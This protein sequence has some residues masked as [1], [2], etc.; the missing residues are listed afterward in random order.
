M[1]A[2][3]WLASLLVC[4]AVAGCASG[5]F[6]NLAD[7]FQVQ[8]KAERRLVAGIDFYED[9][10]YGTASQ[11]LQSSLDAGLRSISDQTRAHKYLAFIHCVSG[12]ERQ[13]RDEFSKAL[14]IDP[15]F[16]LD[17]AEAGHPIWGL[18]FRSVK[19]KK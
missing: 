18:A 12:R 10:D 6:K 4:A 15:T 11:L 2:C 7:I 19:R 16:D 5:P 1:N 13:C 9:G 8:N 14:E 17:P 3:R